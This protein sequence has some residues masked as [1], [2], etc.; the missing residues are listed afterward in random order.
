MAVAG[1]NIGVKPVLWHGRI[2]LS[3]GRSTLRHRLPLLAGRCPIRLI[4]LPCI[5]RISQL[6]HLKDSPYSTYH[7]LMERKSLRFEV[8]L[9]P[10]LGDEIDNW[11]RK[12]QD[13]PSRAEA[14]RRLIELSLKAAN[15]EPAKRPAK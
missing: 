8:R 10:E 5:R 9:S 1:W 11:R 2:I 4:R 15:E 7:R 14:A 13:I 3:G 6:P 12:Q